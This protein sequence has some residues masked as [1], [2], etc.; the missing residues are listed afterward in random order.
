MQKNIKDLEKVQRRAARF[1][2][3]DYGRR[4]S[5][6]NMLEALGWS[7]LERRRK[8]R[9]LALLGK[10]LNDET[11]IDKSIY[12]TPGHATTRSANNIKLAV[13]RAHTEEFKNS[14]FPRTIRQWNT[15]NQVEIDNIIVST[16]QQRHH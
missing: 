15:T 8:E 6:T 2:T 4:S 10:I 9:R 14:F 1:V 12:T 11:G 13:Y 16:C 5:V 7:T 3:G